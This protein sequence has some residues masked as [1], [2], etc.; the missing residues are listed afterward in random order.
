[1]FFPDKKLIQ[2]DAGKLQMLDV[3]LKDLKANH[4]RALIFTQMSKML[5]ILEEF[6]C[7]HGMFGLE[8]LR[9][10]SFVMILRFRLLVVV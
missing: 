1:M 2:Y 6:L 8:V 5:D 4:H 7:L 9:N 10:R 3:L